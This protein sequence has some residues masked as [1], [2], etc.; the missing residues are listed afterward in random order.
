MVPG[1]NNYMT[2]EIDLSYAIG[3][4]PESVVSNIW[5]SNV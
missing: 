1:Q 4:V 2:L 5:D 3:E